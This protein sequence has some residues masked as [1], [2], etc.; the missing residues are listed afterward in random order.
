MTTELADNGALAAQLRDA[1]AEAARVALTAKRLRELA[2]PLLKRGLR[3]VIRTPVMTV[4]NPATADADNP[5]G[6]V[7][8][9]LL[10]WHG[11]GL[12]WFWVRPAPRDAIG[13]T[14]RPEVEELCPGEDI[15]H[16]A[17]CIAEALRV[18]PDVVRLS[19]SFLR[20]HADRSKDHHST[21]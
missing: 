7:Q 17:R 20:S 3:V 11:E 4:S 18:K 10:R 2:V 8:S 5:R 14:Q 13:T 19:D 12:V 16:A 6:L 9:V 21:I 15:H 1:A